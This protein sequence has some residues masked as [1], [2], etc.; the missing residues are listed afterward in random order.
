MYNNK[1]KV[2]FEVIKMFFEAKCAL[3]PMHL[4]RHYICYIHTYDFLLTRSPLR[5][6]MEEDEEF[7][8]TS[9][10]SS[11]L[12]LPACYFYACIEKRILWLTP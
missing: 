12:S 1:G 8:A 2:P 9:S 6:D 10:S 3:L 5:Y 11:S 4:F 7:E